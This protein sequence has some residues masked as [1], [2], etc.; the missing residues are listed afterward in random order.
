MSPPSRTYRLYRYDS[1][2]KIV[3]GDWLEA[4]SDDDAIALA[5]ARGFGTK[6]EIW[7]G[8]R[9]IAQLEGERRSA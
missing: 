8:E 6:C 4:D 3:S 9:L 2:H 1:V 7:E 5:E